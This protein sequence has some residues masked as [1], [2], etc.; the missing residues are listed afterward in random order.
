MNRFIVTEPAKCIGCRTC[1]VACV[2][3]HEPTQNVEALSPTRFSPRLHV[4]RTL[5]V[6]TPVTCHHC[7]D[8]PCLNACPSGAIFYSGD[9]VQI[10]QSR[11]L[12]CKTCVVACPFGAME[13]ISRPA[14]RN[15]AGVELTNGVKAE[16]HKCDL[17][18]N[19]AQGPAC[20]SVCPTD[21]L[22][23]MDAAAMEEVRRRRQQRSA[24]DSGTIGAVG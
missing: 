10:D 2:L 21:A 3:A 14:Q 8:A 11:C 18:K 9:T 15:F 24:L 12:G 20:V 17:C 1:E 4:V 22:H 5:Q 7:E 23:V 16:A 6:S 13:V 19:R